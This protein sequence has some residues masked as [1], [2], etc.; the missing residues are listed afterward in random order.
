MTEEYWRDEHVQRA[1]AIMERTSL[2]IVLWTGK[3]DD[4]LK[5]EW[6]AAVLVRKPSVLVE[7]GDV[8]APDYIANHPIVIRTFHVDWGEKPGEADEAQL[9]AVMLEI[10]RMLEERG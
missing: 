4:K 9:M 2:N 6:D 8:P 10:K 1:M 3:M 7:V 5:A